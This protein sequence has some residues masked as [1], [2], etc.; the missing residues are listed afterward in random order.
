MP[1]RAWRKAWAWGCALG[2]AAVGCAT[3]A[4]WGAVDLTEPDW[5]V[6]RGQAVW[7]PAE[8]Q[9]ELAGD[10]LVA[11]RRDGTGLVQFSKLWLLVEARQ[12]PG[13]WRLEYPSAGRRREGRG[14]APAGLAWFELI[15]ATR[16]GKAVAVESPAGERIEGQV[17]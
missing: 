6:R 7:Q 3:P 8:G 5:T 9:P 2:L 17:E 16:S 12:E 11:W 14:E 10:L 13:R 4:R 15:E 1:R